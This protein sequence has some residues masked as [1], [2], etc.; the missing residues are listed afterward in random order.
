MPK[1]VCDICGYKAAGPY[2]DGVN[3]CKVC[4]DTAAH[5]RY[6]RDGEALKAPHEQ[7]LQWIAEWDAWIDSL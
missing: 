4:S 5:G 2:P 1:P 7:V 3:R 6:I